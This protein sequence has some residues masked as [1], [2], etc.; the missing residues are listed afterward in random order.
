MRTSHTIFLIKN[1]LIQ[2]NICILILFLTTTVAAQIPEKPIQSNENIVEEKIENIAENTDAE[3][4]YTELV[5][6]LSY[7]KENPMNI[8]SANADELKKL[9]LLNDIQINNLLNYIANTGQLISVYELQFVNGFSTTLIFKILPY[10][11]IEK[12]D[13]KINLSFKNIFQYGRHRLLTRYQI[14][15]E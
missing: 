6:L 12:L 9:I 10:I 14:T 4:D 8:N 2:L 3:L 1:Q 15:P 7:Y 5:E 11:K 13:K